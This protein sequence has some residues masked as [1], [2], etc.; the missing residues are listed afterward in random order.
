MDSCYYLDSGLCLLFLGL[1]K[2]LFRVPIDIVKPGKVGLVSLDRENSA[3][4]E[5]A[6]E[7]L[8]KI[9][10]KKLQIKDFYF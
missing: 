5:L 1:L 7:K 9:K 6:L 2:L 3:N 8:G 10:C 4:F